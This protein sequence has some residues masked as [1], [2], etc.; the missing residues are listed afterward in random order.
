L[1]LRRLELTEFAQRANLTQ[2]A[3]AFAAQQKTIGKK[4]Q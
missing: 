3:R 4:R 1:A 2:Q